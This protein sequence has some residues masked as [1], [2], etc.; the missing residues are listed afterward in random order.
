MLTPVD[1]LIDDIS[2]HNLN[3][4]NQTNPKERQTITHNY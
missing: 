3:K 2:T 4:L 1:M